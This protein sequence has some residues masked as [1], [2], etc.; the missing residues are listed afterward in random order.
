M[1]AAFRTFWLPCRG[2]AAEEYE[3]AAAA[4]PGSGRF[5]VADG[6]GSSAFPGAWARLLVEEF[7]RGGQ[8]GFEQWAAAL[9]DLPARWEA[10]IR[11]Q[12]LPWFAERKLHNGAAATFLGVALRAGH[13]QAIAIGDTCLFHTREGV[14]LRAVPLERAAQ[15]TDRPHLLGSRTVVGDLLD[16]RTCHA[17]GAFQPRDR[18]WLATDALAQWCL[19]EHAAG[20]QPWAQIDE[21]L[22]AAEGEQWFAPWIEQLRDEGRLQN[23]DVTLMAITLNQQ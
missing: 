17:E 5:A 16:P 3:D 22:A 11:R 13:W 1:T 20:G 10:A 14:L 2:N 4:E 18:L 15:F 8:G 9:A 23:D 19:A 12:P 21:R 7:T 6:A